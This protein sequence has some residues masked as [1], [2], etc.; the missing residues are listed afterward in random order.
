MLDIQNIE[1]HLLAISCIGNARTIGSVCIDSR[2][3]PNNKALAFFA[4]VTTSGNGHNYIEDAYNKGVRTFVISEKLEELSQQFQD[5]Y[6]IYV[7]DTLASLQ[8][9]AKAYRQTLSTHIVAITGSNGKTI[10]KEML[11]AMLSPSISEIYRSPASYNSQIGVALSLLGIPADCRIAFIETGI[12]Q[13]F[14]MQKLQQMINPDEVIITHF[15]TAHSENFDSLNTLYTEKLQLAKGPSTK[16]I[17]YG[18][19]DRDIEVILSLLN[20]HLDP[21]IKKYQ[22]SESLWI[23]KLGAEFQRLDTLQRHNLSLAL[24]FIQISLPQYL[25]QAI[26]QIPNIGSLPMRMELIENI[27]GHII[28]NDSYSNDLDS[29]QHAIISLTQRGGDTIVLGAME[30]IKN[31][32]L[33]LQQIKTLC[34]DFS[35]KHLF[36]VAWEDIIID[37]NWGDTAVYKVTHIGELLNLYRDQLLQTKVLLVKGARRLHLERLVQHLSLKEHNTRLEVD[38]SALL[39]NLSFYRSLLSQKTKI[40]SMIKADAYGLGA[41]AI[42]KALEKSGH[43]SYLAVAVADEGKEL[44][45]KGIKSPIIVMN[46]QIDSI[47]TLD[48]YNLEAEVYSID[49]LSMFAHKAHQGFRPKLHIKVNTGMNRLGFAPDTYER[50]ADMIQQYDLTIESVFSHLAAADDPKEIDR[51]HNQARILKTFYSQ[52]CHKLQNI[53]YNHNMP[54]LHLLNTAGIETL[55]DTYS[56][57]GVRLGIGLYGF[58]PTGCKEVQTVAKLTTRILDIQFVK[59]GQYV[60]Y[61]NSGYVEHDCKIAIL[62]IGYADGL[63]RRYGNGRWAMSIHGILCPTIGNICMDTCMVDISKLEQVHIGDLVYIFGNKET[64][65]EAMADV[66]GTIPYEILTSISP[67]VARI[68]Y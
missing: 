33:L 47:E 11:Y 60:G 2:E 53:G 12:S 20:L 10:V 46:P 56:F 59:K 26:A 45:R 27:Y 34:T 50:I 38:L 48:R 16:N 66:A 63:S 25:Q 44:R 42:A 49:M 36:L 39:S 37:D 57:D 35:I 13:P 18:T 64:S 5:A 32:A 30:S 4:L 19:T 24:G 54:M 3:L 58:S 17:F 62:P 21:Y 29:L 9:L 1:K 68:Y 6:F 28:I 43:V 31:K 40:V 15:G 23:N 22:C 41:T 7:K 52:L 67:R 65:I 8:S 61:G 14:E 55:A 51:T